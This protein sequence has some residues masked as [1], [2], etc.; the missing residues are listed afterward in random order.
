MKAVTHLFRQ[1]LNWTISILL[2]LP[3]TTTLLYLFQQNQ[4][5]ESHHTK[6]ESYDGCYTHMTYRFQ[7]R[8]HVNVI[9][10]PTDSLILFQ[11]GHH[12]SAF[13]LLDHLP[14]RLEIRLALLFMNSG[15]YYGTVGIFSVPWYFFCILL[16]S[17]GK[18]LYNDDD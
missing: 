7:K 4:T 13:P 14:W 17:I 6:R 2:S 18:S 8:P 16:K 9:Y 1:V 11:A 5:F 10:Y 3:S 15:K 12:L